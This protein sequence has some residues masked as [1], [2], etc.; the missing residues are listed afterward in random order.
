MHHGRLGGAV[1]RWIAKGLGMLLFVPAALAQLPPLLP[2]QNLEVGCD[3]VLAYDSEVA[4]L[5]NYAFPETNARY[6]IALVSDSAPAG[7]RLRIDGRYPEARYSAFHIH[8][9]TLFFFDAISDNQI[10]PAPGSGN[11]NLDRTRRDGT[12]EPGGEYTAYA[13]I[14]AVSPSLDRPPNTIYRRPPQRLDAQAKRRSALAYRT[15]LA[16]G[17]NTGGVGLPKLTL[18]TPNGEFP[19]PHA[20]DAAVCAGIAAQLTTPPATLPISLL[21]PLIPSPRPVFD[22]FDG[23]A[24]NALGLGVGL[25]PHNGFMTAKIDRDYNDLVLV[26]GKLPSYTTQVDAG[27]VP[28]VRYWSVCQNGANST[29]VHGCLAD[30][31]IERD[32]A[33]FYNIVI[34][35]EADRPAA[36][37]AEYGWLAFG[38]EKIGVTI[39]RELL[40]HAD[41]DESIERSS[42]AATAAE[43]GDFMPRMTYCAQA[44]FDAALAAGQSP[45][46]TFDACAQAVGL[47]PPLLPL[48]SSTPTPVASPTVTVTP[49]SAP[50][51]SATATPTSTPSGAPTPTPGVSPT[52]SA[53]LMPTVTPSSSVTPTPSPSVIAT[54]TPT[55]RISPTPSVTAIPSPTSTPTLAPSPSPVVPVTPT[56]TVEPT[57]IPTTTPA[58]TP[59]PTPVIVGESTPTPTSTPAPEPSFPPIVVTPDPTPPSVADDSGGGGVGWVTLILLG[60]VGWARA[61]RRAGPKA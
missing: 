14:N 35:D 40:A 22:K 55:P 38:P 42:G 29:R 7:S 57:P 58:V 1:L 11:R 56:S 41:F 50:S 39:V 37:P 28:Q 3:W 16:E 61:R 12:V 23:E 24:L 52:P 49:T 53:T 33:G 60:S 45:A 31:D 47:F 36:L 44:V 13:R 9:G 59:T 30:Q 43:R 51:P 21:P 34:S 46:G 10:V 25:N 20:A 8:D 17:D 18:E 54:P 48:P 19:L 27:P 5:G 4:G 26:R 32:T 6:W 2:A 15:Y